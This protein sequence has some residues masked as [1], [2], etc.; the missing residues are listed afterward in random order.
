MAKIRLII[1]IKNVE[2]DKIKEDIKIKKAREVNIAKI[3]NIK[4]GYDKR[5]IIFIIK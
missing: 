4:K 5:N 3:I 1:Y 2:K